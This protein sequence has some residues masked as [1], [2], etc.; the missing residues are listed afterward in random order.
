MGARATPHPAPGPGAAAG[1]IATRDARTCGNREPAWTV[2]GRPPKGGWRRSRV[3][4]VIAMSALVLFAA[5]CTSEGSRATGP[6]RRSTAEAP[7][8]DPTR[9]EIYTAAFRSLAETEGWFDPVLLDERL[10]PNIAALG[11]RGRCEDRFTE[12]EQ[13]AILG[14]LADLPR[15]RFVDD[16]KRI[17]D[18]I[19]SGRLRGGGLLTV[20]GID[21]DDDLVTVAG[22]SYCGGLCAHWMTLVIRNRPAGWTVTG[23][24]GPVGIA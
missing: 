3:R 13:A 20:G 19:F 16:A 17:Q 18:Q 24:T 21:G 8:S 15:V 5:A 6:S 14:G 23:T 22:R 1:S 10:C 7:G 12:A 9:V 4:R 2:R 11:G